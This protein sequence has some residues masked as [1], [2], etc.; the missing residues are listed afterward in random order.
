MAD[1]DELKR[2]LEKH[3]DEI[4]LKMHLASMEAKEEW[5][6]LE[7]KWHDFKARTHVEQSGEAIGD[8]VTGL[9]E[10]LRQ[11]YRRFKQGL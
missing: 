1:M 4:K 9:G 3:R 10:E 6:G 5:A 7:K 11:A 8:A 2:D